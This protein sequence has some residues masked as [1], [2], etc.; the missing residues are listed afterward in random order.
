MACG[1]K[2]APV[3]PPASAIPRA[4]PEPGPAT[5]GAIEDL[6][7]GELRAL[8]DQLRARRA[9]LGQLTRGGRAELAAVEA[10][11]G[12]P[13]PPP[14]LAPGLPGWGPFP[15][16]GNAFADVLGWSEDGR[17]FG[18]ALE[19]GCRRVT[20]PGFGGDRR[21]REHWTATAD[22]RPHSRRQGARTGSAS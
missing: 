4:L 12:E 6:S 8:A 2:A 18:L 7:E 10:R 17:L 5:V 20:E 13:S 16:L 14:E 11:L 1:P 3:A 9:L 21:R 19:P 22:S 15:P